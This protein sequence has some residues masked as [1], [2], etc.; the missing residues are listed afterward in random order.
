MKYILKYQLSYCWIWHF[1]DCNY[2]EYSANCSIRQQQ[3]E[4]KKTSVEESHLCVFAISLSSG[5]Q[6][7]GTDQLLF[8]IFHLLRSSRRKQEEL[9][10][11]SVQDQWG[12]TIEGTVSWWSPKSSMQQWKIKMNNHQLVVT[13]II[14]LHRTELSEFLYNMLYWKTDKFSVHVQNIHIQY[15]CAVSVPAIFFSCSKVV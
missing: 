3:Q 6:T 9:I 4:W 1:W 2:T 11:P 8:I 13:V 15:R 7:C 10:G 12:S 5:L 14:T